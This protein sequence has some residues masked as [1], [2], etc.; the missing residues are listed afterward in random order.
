MSEA[1]R[2]SKT[3]SEVK[4]RYNQKTYDVIAVRVPKEMASAFK[5]KCVAEDIPQAQIIKQAIEEFLKK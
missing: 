5:A 4:T 3:S 1:K 2:K